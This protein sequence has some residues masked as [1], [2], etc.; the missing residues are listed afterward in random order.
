M[1]FKDKTRYDKDGTALTLREEQ[2][3]AGWDSTTYRYTPYSL[4]G[5]RPVTNE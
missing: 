4:K 5:L 3:H 1:G 2:L